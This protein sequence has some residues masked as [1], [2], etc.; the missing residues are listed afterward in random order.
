MVFVVCCVLLIFEKNWRV[1]PTYVLMSEP[2][3]DQ[4]AP[5]ISDQSASEEGVSPS[6]LEVFKAV[7]RLRMLALDCVS[8]HCRQR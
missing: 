3:P 2:H 5:R 1:G 4:M 6:A 8:F 7:S